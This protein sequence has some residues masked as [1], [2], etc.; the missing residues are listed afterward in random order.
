M[1]TKQNTLAYWALA[2][3]VGALIISGLSYYSTYQRDQRELES[4]RPTIDMTSVAKD[5][6]HWDL[7]VRISNRSDHRIKVVGFSI[8]S[9]KGGFI[10]LTQTYPTGPY[11]S[12]ASM[13]SEGAETTDGRATM[14]NDGIIYDA[15]Y[16]I[17]DAFPAPP[18][19]A[20]TLNATIRHL[21]PTEYDEVI[22]VTRRLN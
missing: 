20:L 18:D 2:V 11:G 17:S 13:N 22:T 3:S 21:G 9:P 15:E 6:R 19:V 14:A 16:Q 4:K 5:A 1:E 8:P 7:N 10:K 12:G